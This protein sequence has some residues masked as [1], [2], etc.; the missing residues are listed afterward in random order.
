MIVVSRP[1]LSMQEHLQ[2][3]WS[4]CRCKICHDVSMLTQNPIHLLNVT[5]AVYEKILVTVDISQHDKLDIL[6][7]DQ[8]L[9]EALNRQLMHTL[10]RTAPQELCF[11]HVQLQAVCTHPFSCIL[12]TGCNVLT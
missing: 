10:T 12:H 3:T 6:H 11:G 5:A 7:R 2:Q 9:T 8:R 1:N 4:N